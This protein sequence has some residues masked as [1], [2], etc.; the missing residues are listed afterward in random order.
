MRMPTSAGTI[1]WV[2][3]VVTSHGWHVGLPPFGVA[4]KKLSRKGR[5]GLWWWVG[6]KLANSR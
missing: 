4:R 3:T 6:T 5:I 2:E 1:T